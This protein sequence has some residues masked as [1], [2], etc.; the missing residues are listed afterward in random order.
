MRVRSGGVLTPQKRALYPS[1]G[2][3][4]LSYNAS[5][6]RLTGSISYV[7]DCLY[8]LRRVLKL[9]LLQVCHQAH[10]AEDKGQTAPAA[11][12]SPAEELARAAK[13]RWPAAGL[14]R[15]GP[16]EPRGTSTAHFHVQGGHRDV[17]SPQRGGCSRAQGQLGSSN[18]EGTNA[19]CP[20][21]G[22]TSRLSTRP[23][24]C[25]VSLQPSGK[26]RRLCPSLL[27]SSTRWEVESPV[28]GYTEEYG[29]TRATAPTPWLT[30]G[31]CGEPAV[32]WSSVDH[33]PFHLAAKTSGPVAGKSCCTVHGW[34]SGHP[35]G[36]RT[37]PR[38]CLTSACRPTNPCSRYT[39]TTSGG[40]RQWPPSCATGTS[41]TSGDPFACT[42]HIQ[43]LNPNS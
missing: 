14:Q 32:S 2:I 10:P 43:L 8:T 33:Q 19:W 42:R 35:A 4:W 26:S 7:Q 16:A 22:W 1:R 11:A 36:Q 12:A 31:G 5:L 21:R 34:R 3:L 13:G 40:S 24:K 28:T 20:C 23:L 39:A 15:V 9:D 29:P 37:R 41:T 17:S 25:H 38:A 27:T 6:N 30:A 18:F